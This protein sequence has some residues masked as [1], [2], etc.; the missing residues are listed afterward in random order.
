MASLELQQISE[1]ASQILTRSSS[2]RATSHS[3]SRSRSRQETPSHFTPADSTSSLHVHHSSSQVAETV[4]TPLP[5]SR[6]AIVIA[7]L[8]GVTFIT[9]F[10]SGLL[11]VGLPAI[12][13]DLNLESELTVWPLS[14]YSLTSGTCFLIGGAIADVLGSR[15]V[16]LTGCF[17]VAVFILGCGL[18][19]TGLELVMFRACQG[20]ASA[21]VAP[22]SVALIST[23][24][25]TGKPRN[26]GFACLGTAMPLGFSFGLVLGGVLATG[27]G[28][29]WGF[30]IVAGLGA[31]FFAVGIW[32]L[33]RA[34]TRSVSMRSAMYRLATEI[35]WVGALLASAAIAILSYFMAYVSLI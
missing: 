27:L 24:V 2:R 1:N 7:Q 29:R 19:R 28:W 3:R 17:L 14:V 5:S 20:I 33:P 25:K 6:A 9:S 13:R 12:T 8:A 11:T 21:L 22:S 4:Q 34:E 31:L 30:Y 10:T 16:N 32:A 35:D 23:S 15:A 18:A 26:I